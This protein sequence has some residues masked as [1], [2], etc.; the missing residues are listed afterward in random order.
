M[1]NKMVYFRCGTIL[2]V[3][4]FLIGYISTG[5]YAQ[6]RISLPEPDYEGGK[7]LEEVIY[8]RKSIRRFN[9]SPL[10]IKEISQLMWSAGGVTVDGITGPTRA[11]P[12]AGGIY[13]LEIYLVAGDVVGLAAGV[14]Q[15]DWR[16]HSVV[17]LRKGDFRGALSEASLR[18]RMVRDA[19]VSIVITAIFEKTYSRY[20]ERGRNRYVP[21]DVGHLGQNVHLQAESLGLATVMVGSFS[22]EDVAEVLGTKQGTPVYI[23]PVGKTTG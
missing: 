13:P 21:M 3:I 1:K 14:Y 2:L 19:P 10:A 17:L 7:S 6:D 8:S 5:V 16:T 12:S 4:M 9:D 18:Q 11:Y 23:M 15:Y 20:K 22:D